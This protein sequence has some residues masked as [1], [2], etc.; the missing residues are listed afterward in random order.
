MPGLSQTSNIIHSQKREEV[1]HVPNS[2]S[3][4]EAFPPAHAQPKLEDVEWIEITGVDGLLRVR[5][6]ERQ[7]R[8]GDRGGAELQA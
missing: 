8:L 6:K 7:L 2:N 4:R 3:T 1:T 5:W